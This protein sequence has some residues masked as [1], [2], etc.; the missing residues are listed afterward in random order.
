MILN[1]K[2]EFLL[3]AIPFGDTQEPTISAN[4]YKLAYSDGF[5]QPTQSSQPRVDSQLAYDAPQ[6]DPKDPFE[7]NNS[8]NV[9][10]A[11]P[12]ADKK[13]FSN[14]GFSHGMG[15]LTNVING[16][17]IDK[18]L[19]GDSDKDFTKE[20]KLLTEEFSREQNEDKKT[21][22]SKKPAC[23]PSA[24]SI[25]ANC[26]KKRSAVCSPEGKYIVFYLLYCRNFQI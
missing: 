17:M 26:K 18:V 10:I 12:F 14:A 8:N 15:Q 19:N 13:L 5:P 23:Q 20:L 3:S 6:D 24:R 7:D 9:K 4:D 16:L 1:K 2:C 21:D 25:F 11:D 22:Q